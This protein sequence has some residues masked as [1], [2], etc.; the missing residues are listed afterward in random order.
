MIPNAA[1]DD[2]PTP[3]K[4]RIGKGLRGWYEHVQGR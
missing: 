3:G 1:E 2:K 4:L